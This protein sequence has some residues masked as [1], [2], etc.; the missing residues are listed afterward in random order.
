[1]HRG[2]RRMG[3]DVRLVLPG[4]CLSCFGQIT[5]LGPASTT[6][7][8]ALAPPPSSAF[9]NERLG[10]LRSLNTVAAGLGQTLLEQ[11][12]DGRLTASTWLQLDVD[13]TGVPRLTHP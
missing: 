3:A 9:Q 1:G 2:G 6:L 5:G 7:L 8:Q 10:S 12:I 11:L 13:D 4:R